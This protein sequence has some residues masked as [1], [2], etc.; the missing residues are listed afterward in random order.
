MGYKKIDISNSG[1]RKN[2]PIISFQTSGVV[3]LNKGLVDDLKL[4]IGDRISFLQDEIEY[5][6]IYINPKDKGGFKLRLLGAEGKAKSL[7]F[8]CSYLTKM[9]L[10]LTGSESAVSCRV[11]KSNAKINGE[12]CFLV[13]IPKP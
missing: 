7:G 8:N 1:H 12:N 2:E 10:E 13:I 6:D 3:R 4:K 9:I 11:S 5:R